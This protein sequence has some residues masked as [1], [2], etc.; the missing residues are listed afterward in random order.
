MKHVAVD[1]ALPIGSFYAILVKT[2][3]TAG[4]W[5]GGVCEFILSRWGMLDTG[6]CR[7]TCSGVR[8]GLRMRMRMR[9]RMEAAFMY[10]RTLFDTTCDD[11]DM[12]SVCGGWLCLVA[13]WLRW[14]F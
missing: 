14:S 13:A 1:N 8:M 9:M 10:L 3:K 11:D 6:W 12:V 7:H 2:K 5:R 4:N